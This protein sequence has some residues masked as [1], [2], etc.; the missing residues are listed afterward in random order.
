VTEQG[1]CHTQRVTAGNALVWLQRW[2][3]RFNDTMWLQ[4]PKHQHYLNCN[5]QGTQMRVNFVFYRGDGRRWSV[6][7]LPSS[8]YGTTPGS[9]NVSVG[10]VICFVGTI[11]FYTVRFL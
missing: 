1:Q 10:V 6:A 7:S 2:T 5:I 8:G 9:S 4:T 3:L 11:Y